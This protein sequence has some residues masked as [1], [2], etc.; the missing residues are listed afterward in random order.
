M[1]EFSVGLYMINIWPDS[2]LFAAIYG[3]VEAASTTLFGP[4]VGTWV[5]KFPYKQLLRMWLL[6]RSLSFLAAGGAVTALLVYFGPASHSFM[7]FMALVVLTNI[8]G[9]VSV[10]STLAGTILIEREWVVIISFGHHPEVRTRMNSTIR[11]IDLVC[12]LLAPVLTGFIISFVSLVASALILACWNVLSVWLEYYLWISVYDGIPALSESRQRR[13]VEGFINNYLEAPVRELDNISIEGTMEQESPTWI[14]KITESLSKLFCFDA[15]IVYFNQDVVLPGISLA[16]I[17][18]TV[19]SFGTLMTAA[20]EWKGIPAYIIG[21]ARGISAVIGIMATVV[22][23]NLQSRISTL[24][25]G[26]WSIW[27][28]WSFLLVCL[29]SVWIHNSIT[30]AW[31]LMGGV[32][33]SRLGLWMFDLSVMQLMQEQ[34]SEVDR[35]V[36]GGVQSSLQSMLDLLTYIMGIVVSDP[37]DFGLLVILSFIIV[38]SAAILYTLH[39]YRIR[40]HLFHFEKILAKNN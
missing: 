1:W 20:L 11:R 23:P 30:S 6:T 26:L 32:A 3:V 27:A 31:L 16:L 21:I 38:S 18:F 25:T 35:C 33:A 36:V 24:R 2:L 8:S 10:L 22:Y 9:A 29:A 28:Q 17:Y 15:W 34:V 4:V 13:R 37:R 40:K 12:K 19:L 39:C 7:P 14:S 5:E